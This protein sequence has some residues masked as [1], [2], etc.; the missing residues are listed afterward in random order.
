MTQIDV[1]IVIE[2][3]H[4]R[5]TR[6]APIWSGW[7]EAD[8]LQIL[9][10]HRLLAALRAGEIDLRGLRVLLVQ[11]H[12]YS[13]HFT[14]YLTALIS[15]LSSFD[16]VRSL[17]ENLLEE[18][19]V[20]GGSELTHAELLQRSLRSI[21]A[22]THKATPLPQTNALIE[23]MLRHCRSVDPLDGLAAL[24]LGAESIVPLLYS[25][26]AEALTAQGFDDDTLEFF[27]LHIAEDEGHALAIFAILERL[28][29]N[30][31]AAHARA[32][33]VGR[34]VID[35]RAEMFDAIWNE[36][37]SGAAADEPAGTIG[38][39]SSADFWR[40]PPKLSAQ[41]HERLRH[42]SVIAEQDSGSSRFSDERNHKVHIVDLPTHT[43]S[44]TIGRLDP[45]Q[46]TRLHR[47][48]YE[49]LIYVIAGQGFSR[50]GSRVVDWKA[51]DAVYVPVWAA[52]QHVN[53]GAIECV[54][55]ACENAPLLQNLG[56]IAMREELAPAA[57]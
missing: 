4:D 25:P 45:S 17:T 2:R 51:G 24:G 26:I 32:R 14:R 48:N 57:Q 54:Y 43:I 37:Q 31:P 9:T 49:T 18:L 39:S 55:V 46:S 30:R 35:R 11:H 41:A 1:D 19:G 38:R 34:E 8:D 15:R 44:M 6:P 10:E 29:S 56:S 22:E 28:T 12:L 13:R 5:A 20:E 36:I 33:S 53:T 23:T 7:L 47:H 27:R 42:A 40:V 21:G 52:H 3:S 50:I 16:D